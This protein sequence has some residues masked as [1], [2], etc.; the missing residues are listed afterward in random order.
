[1]V[2]LVAWPLSG[3]RPKSEPEVCSFCWFIPSELCIFQCN[4]FA[5]YFLLMDISL[6]SRLNELK[7]EH[8]V[9]PTKWLW[10]L[11]RWSKHHVHFVYAYCYL[12]DLLLCW[13][14]SIPE[15]WILNPF[16]FKDLYENMFPTC[17]TYDKIPYDT[18]WFATFDQGN[19]IGAKH[20]SCDA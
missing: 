1:M 14:Q 9:L 2:Q 10:I 16:D 12:V 19:Q 13:K 5:R 15:S 20:V 7:H 18:K 8:F 3:A 4:Y 11:L 6:V 17:F